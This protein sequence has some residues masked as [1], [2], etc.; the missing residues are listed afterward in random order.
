[1]GSKM[2]MQRGR[3]VKARR[4][5]TASG[6]LA[7]E[8]LHAS[9]PASQEVVPAALHKEVCVGPRAEAISAPDSLGTLLAL[10]MVCP[11]SKVGISLGREGKGL[12]IA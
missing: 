6:G 10:R 4:M 1:M 7:A 3:S 8:E 12:G 2:M 5:A 9:S 11:G